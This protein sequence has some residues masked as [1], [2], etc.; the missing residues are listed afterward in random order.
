MLDTILLLKR[1]KFNF[2]P[3]KNWVFG[4]KFIHVQNEWVEK[5]VKNKH[6]SFINTFYNCKQVV[7]C[8]Y[9]RC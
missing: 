6:G 9:D 5:S 8:Q 2:R 7:C 1:Q 3:C 4:N